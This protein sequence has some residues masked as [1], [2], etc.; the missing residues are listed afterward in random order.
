MGPAQNVVFLW[1][2]LFDDIKRSYNN[3]SLWIYMRDLDVKVK[4]SCWG[5]YPQRRHQC[6]GVF[7]LSLVIVYLPLWARSSLKLNPYF[8]NVTGNNDL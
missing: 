4:L 8:A 3:M 1:R 7:S 2:F 6:D 5:R